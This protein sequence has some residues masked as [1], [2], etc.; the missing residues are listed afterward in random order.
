[1]RICWTL[2]NVCLRI[3]MWARYLSLVLLL[4]VVGCAVVPTVPQIGYAAISKQHLE[5]LDRWSLSGRIAIT[6]PEDSW[7]ANMVWQRAGGED[8]IQLSGPFGQ[9]AVNVHLALNEVTVDRGDGKMERSSD[10]DEFVRTQLGVFVPVRSLAY[11]VVGLPEPTALAVYAEQGFSQ[12]EWLVE[13]KEW[14][15]VEHKSMPRKV[16]VTNGKLRL[17][18]VC[19]QWEIKK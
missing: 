15:D 14:Q 6:S 7:S 13:Y 12:K 5:A 2:K 4:S 19:D 3:D 11:W 16:V 18:L 1:M 8:N 9:G 10:P 17:K